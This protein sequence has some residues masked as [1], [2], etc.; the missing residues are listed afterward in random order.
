MCNLKKAKK[1]HILIVRKYLLP[2]TVGIWWLQTCLTWFRP[3]RRMGTNTTNINKIIHGEQTNLTDQW[4]HSQKA[5]SYGKSQL[6]SWQ[7][8]IF[9]GSRDR[10]V[11]FTL[12][13]LQP[14]FWIEIG[15]RKKDLHFMDEL[16]KVCNFSSTFW[17]TFYTLSLTSSECTNLNWRSI[18][19]KR[20]SRL[21]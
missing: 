7:K 17:T 16:I 2:N 9:N 10:N 19:M 3:Y 1:H 12:L 4:V 11:F 20:N 6:P 8:C 13:L 21:K 18:L 15:W 5:S 14:L